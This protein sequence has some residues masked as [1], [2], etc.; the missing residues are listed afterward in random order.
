MSAW[1]L[2][3]AWIYQGIMAI[4]NWLYD[5]GVFRSQGFPLP[6]ICI[7]N[8]SMGGTGKTPHTEYLIRLLA[9]HGVKLAVLSR[10]YGRHTK[11][12]RKVADS[13]SADECGDEPWQMA[14]AAECPRD[15]KFYVCENRVEGIHKLLEDTSPQAILLDDAF[16]H[17]RVKA[18]LNLLLTEYDRPYASDHVVPAGRL[19]EGRKGARRA[20]VILVTKCP[21]QLEPE[22]RER[23]L[24]RLRPAPWQ[25]VFFTR[26]SYGECRPLFP[27]LAQASPSAATAGAP[28]TALALC[29]IARP[30][31]FLSQVEKM[32]HHTLSL[33]F[34]DHHPF[35]PADIRKMERKAAG[36]CKVV[37][38]EK[39]G[40]RLTALADCLPEALKAKLWV[41]PI[42]V[43]FLHDEADT[44]NEIISRYVTENTRNRR[45]DSV[46][47]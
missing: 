46:T 2:P 19:R 26:F 34:P 10:G 20:Q 21:E 32:F 11:G 29:G 3:L 40:A 35:T 4:R 7:G 25:S 28:E 43:A 33:T 14:H 31:P 22:V 47:H 15:V 23:M 27:H 45:V 12:F 16:Q 38:T 42:R 37:T 41:L 5:I 36:C 18:G 9:G 13:R 8:L 44:F 24:R 1:F 30:R 17:R 39:D 6:V